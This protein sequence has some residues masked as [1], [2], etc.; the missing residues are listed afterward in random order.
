MLKKV[1]FSAS[2]SETIK[3]ILLKSVTL[4][5]PHTWFAPAWAFMV[6]AIASHSIYF[7]LGPDG[8]VW[9][10]IL[11]LGKV[12]IGMAMAGPLLTG[13]SQVLNDY[14]DRDVDA[15]N[16]PDRLIPSG[17]VSE[18]QVYVTIFA[19][20]FAAL[21]VGLFLGPSV[22]LMCAVG[23][24]LAISYSVH[25]L[26]LKRNGWIGNLT[27]AVAYEGLAWIAG[28]LTFQSPITGPS[29]ALA[30]L[31]SLGA[32][33]IMTINDFKSVTGDRQMGILSIP[34]LYGEQMAAWLAVITMNAAQVIVIV[35]L[36][37]WGSPIAAGVVALFTAGQWPS[38]YK[39]IRQPVNEMAVKYNIVA[40]PL[41]VWGMVAAA[42]GLG[43]L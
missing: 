41:Y 23:L 11:S 4:M 22:M 21:A 19:L 5:K 7:N 31:Y 30:L 34:V 38:Q 13:F 25:P 12:A 15:I 33:G 37:I 17:Q 36:L 26:R 18:I 20:A 27:V 6:G 42:I 3:T 8:D 14:C 2:R 43:V 1:G 35:L 32:H 24:G 39:L 9:Q 40:I 10:S 29:L 28:H 16:Q